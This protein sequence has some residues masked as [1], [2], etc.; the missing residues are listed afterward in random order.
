MLIYP[1]IDLLGGRCV[2]LFQGDYRQETVYADDPAA[3]AQYLEDHGFTHLH[4]VDLE[5]AREKKVIHWP[6]IAA[7]L[8]TTN[9][10]VDFGGGIRTREEVE[11]LFDLGIDK[12][13]IGSLAYREP[14]LF[15]EW[16]SA[17]GASQI[18]L[19][20]DVRD[21]FIATHGWQTTES[22]ALVDYI[23]NMQSRGIRWLT[24]TDISK[25]GAMA[26]PATE[27][28]REISQ[29]FPGQNLI[30]SGGIRHLEDVEAVRAA[31]CTGAI[32]GKAIYEKTIDLTALVQL[33]TS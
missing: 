22:M 26:G 9:L 32:I 21:G 15:S 30:A 16:I 17:F 1:A 14:E 18:I 10:T 25:D 4:L 28:Y 8:H 3:M 23:A 24:V 2:R 27:L 6:Q 13:N 20:A 12:V 5:G 33:Q 31:G 19:S 7:I 11:R 29:A